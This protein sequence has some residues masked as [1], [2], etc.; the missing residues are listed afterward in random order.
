MSPEKLARMANQIAA[1]FAALPEDEAARNVAQHLNDFW[2][3]AMRA[4]LLDLIASGSGRLHP[5]VHAAVP[6]LR[7]PAEARA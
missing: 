1:V 3:P 7:R 4:E 2:A 6:H 5:L